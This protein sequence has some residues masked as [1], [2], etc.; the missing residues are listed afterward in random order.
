M[1]LETLTLAPAQSAGEPETNLI[2]TGFMATGKT[3]VGRAVA[4]RL[5]RPFVDM[6]T[7]IEAR[8]G[9]PIPCIF[10]EEGEAAFR[11][12]EAALCRE[13]AA[14]SGLVIATGG[15][16]LVEEANRKLMMQSGNVVC[17]VCSEDEILRRVQAEDGRERPLL[18]VPDPHAE[19][20]RLLARRQP[21]YC[22][23]PWW[24]DSTG[25]A[26][27]AVVE[28]VAAF[29]GVVTL[30][31]CSPGGRDGAEYCIHIGDGLLDQ[32]GSALRAAGAPEG[33]RVA[34]VSNTVV[35]PLYGARAEAALQAAGLAP[36]AC[37]IPDGEAHKT[38]GT[39]AALYDQFLAGG[40]DRGD[41]VLALGGGVTGDIAG[42]TAASF[43][44]GVRCAQ[45]PTTLL[46]M[47][48]SSVGGKT[49]VD[50][51]QG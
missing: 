3:A 51:P 36:F 21:A 22:A 42:F 8:A 29:A 26:L 39:V 32:L 14:R 16:A 35:A 48:D 2:L 5:G 6:D 10:A 20:A 38:L 11:Q 33:S 37:T 7:E 43:M 12:M 49:G 1:K 28:R 34:V 41:T 15:G 45:A 19:I 23:I 9:K 24:V 17:L 4:A 18:D 40:L 30:P 44:R 31:V 47:T 13:L 50:L 25:L 27:E 46:A